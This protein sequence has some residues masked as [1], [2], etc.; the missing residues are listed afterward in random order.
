MVAR[1]ILYEMQKTKADHVF[2]DVTHLPASLVTT[3]FPQIYRFCMDAGLDITRELIPVAPAAHYQIGGVRVNTWG[4]TNI[5]GI[6]AV[7]EVACTGVHGA[8]R[9]AS[10]SLLEAV[11]FSRRIVER[12]TQSRKAPAIQ[13]SEKEQLFVLKEH[14]RPMK[15]PRCSLPNLRSLMWDKVGIIRSGEDL[16]C[17]AG[18]LSAWESSLTE[19]IDRP[20]FEA[21]NLISVA[22][23]MTEAALL[24]KESRGAHFRTDFPDQSPGMGKTHHI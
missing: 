14:E 9:L 5:R 18:I 6:Y 12:S 20:F 16:Q 22:R 2:L 21:A 15:I 10:N 3:R 13:R 11:V 7:G 19:P 23:I 1:S 8:N 24:R 17:M 4:E